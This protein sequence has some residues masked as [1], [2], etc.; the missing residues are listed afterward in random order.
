MK[1]SC[2]EIVIPFYFFQFLTIS[3]KYTGLLLILIWC[4]PKPSCIIVVQCHTPVQ[5]QLPV[6]RKNGWMLF[7]I[8]CLSL[9]VH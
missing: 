4:F 9:S 3:D 7:L 6:R 1:T 2:Q 5:V 8:C